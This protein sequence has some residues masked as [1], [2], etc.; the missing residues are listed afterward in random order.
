M[1]TLV[2]LINVHDGNESM[3]QNGERLYIAN[4]PRTEKIISAFLT[5]GWKLTSRTQRFNPAIQQEGSL[6]FYLGSW[7]LL[8]EKV[9]EDDVEDDGDKI[10]EEVL[11]RFFREE[12]KSASYR[13]YS[14]DDYAYFGEEDEE[15]YDLK[16]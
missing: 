9:V 12:Y 5:N 6:S 15:L 3:K 14:P 1:K 4:Y 11:D 13:P 8:F 7:D 16:F 10:L 2:K